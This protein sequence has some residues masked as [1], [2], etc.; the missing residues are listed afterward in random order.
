M[1]RLTPVSGALALLLLAPPASAQRR[2][3]HN[4]VFSDT[5]PAAVIA[6]DSSVISLGTQSF[7]LYGVAN[8]EQH[9]FAKLDGKRINRFG[10]HS[11]LR[12]SITGSSRWSMT[13][14]VTS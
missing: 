9:F 7:V 11:R 1:N 8:A 12:C 6:L 14:G 13:T 5:L 4:R 2:V 3:E 10:S